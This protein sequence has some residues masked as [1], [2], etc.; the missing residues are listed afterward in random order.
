MF[1]IDFK[2][3]NVVVGRWGG[4]EFVAVCYDSD[5]ENASAHAEEIRKKITEEEFKVVGN[6]SSSIG[7][8]E[9]SKED[10]FSAAFDRMD[11]ALYKAKND[12]RNRVEKG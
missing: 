2:K 4:E 7:L 5:I 11:K 6:I 8:T 12:G 3:S 1:D 10:R 9:I